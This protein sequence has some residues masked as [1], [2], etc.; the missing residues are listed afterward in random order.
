MGHIRYGS[1]PDR[2]EM[3]DRA[4]AHVKVVI[5][6]KL[7]RNEA[8]AF[9]WDTD[10]SGGSGR[11]TIWLHPRVDLWFSFLGSR[12]PALNRAWVDALMLTANSVDGLRLV[13]EPPDTSTGS[14]PVP[15]GA[16]DVAGR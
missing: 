7:R 12:R 5:L 8:F 15:G 1:H 4:L 13:E 11:D 2:I 9:S 3:E 14:I 6:A 10:A 16:S